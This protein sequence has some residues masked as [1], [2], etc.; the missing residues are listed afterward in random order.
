MA[1]VLRFAWG[2]RPSIVALVLRSARLSVSMQSGTRPAVRPSVPMMQHGAR[3]AGSLG[4]SYAMWC[5]LLLLSC[6]TALAGESARPAVFH[7]AWAFPYRMVV[8]LRFARA[9]PCSVAPALRFMLPC[10]ADVAGRSSQPRIPCSVAF[11]RPAVRK[12]KKS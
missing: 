9:F 11:T 10:L 7:A 2:V 6:L 8:F 1:F 3:A 5:S 4:Y 12:T